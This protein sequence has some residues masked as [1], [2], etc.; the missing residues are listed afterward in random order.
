M[1]QAVQSLPKQAWGPEF[2]FQYRPSQKTFSHKSIIMFFYTE[3]KAEGQE[4]K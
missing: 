1:A 3:K 2:N 4:D